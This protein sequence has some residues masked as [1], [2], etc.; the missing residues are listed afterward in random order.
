MKKKTPSIIGFVIIPIIA[1]IIGMFSIDVNVS[2]PWDKAKQHDEVLILDT[3]IKTD[4]FLIDIVES[5]YCISKREKAIYYIGIINDNLLGL[6]N[7]RKRLDLLYCKESLESI[8][9]YKC[10]II[11]AKENDIDKLFLLTTKTLKK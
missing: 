1:A 9:K 11:A 4:T 5:K 3:I 2:L 6:T 10:D 8:S 7:Q